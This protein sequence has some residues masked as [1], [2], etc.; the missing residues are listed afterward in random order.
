MCV[1]INENK[2]KEHGNHQEAY[3]YTTG[4]LGK[5]RQKANRRLSRELTVI[6]V[7]SLLSL[8]VFFCLIRP[9]QSSFA[10]PMRHFLYPRTWRTLLSAAASSEF[11]ALTVLQL[12]E[13]IKSSPEPKERGLLSRLKRKQDLIQYLQQ[14]EQKKTTTI[15]RKLPLRMPVLNVVENDQH[16]LK[17][18]SDQAS[19]PT[20]KA[21]LSPKETIFEEVYQRFPPLRQSIIEENNRKVDNNEEEGD[22]GE[23]ED[24]DIRELYHPFLDCTRNSSSDI[25]IVFLGTASCT[26]GTTRGVSCTAVRLNWKRRQ[27]QTPTL[28]MTELDD[29]DKN[30]QYKAPEY[31]SFVGGTWLF[32]VGECTQV[33]CRILKV[34]RVKDALSKVGKGRNERCWH[35]S[36]DFFCGDVH[37]TFYVYSDAFLRLS[38][39]YRVCF[40]YATVF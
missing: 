27:L 12:K 8:L 37:L 20:I 6:F 24:V 19:A 9:C 22:V 34:L 35:Q 11:D 30:G 7:E 29:D 17:Q 25:D 36:E 33:C 1:D 32:D 31:S 18:G 13:L 38:A 3:S 14:E 16:S 40:V 10:P 5:R 21:F 39:V 2:G 26:P 23:E 15:K 28:I 4:T